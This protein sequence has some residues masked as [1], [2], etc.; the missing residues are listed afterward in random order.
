MYLSELQDNINISGLLMYCRTPFP[1]IFT[2]N[3]ALG[4]IFILLSVLLNTRPYVHSHALK[5]L[6]CPNAVL[7]HLH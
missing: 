3:L 7:V 5:I 6:T 1:Y 2:I 4:I